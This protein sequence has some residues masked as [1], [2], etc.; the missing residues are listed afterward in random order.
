[1]A[2][3]GLAGSL[4]SL[5][6]GLPCVPMTS[7]LC[8]VPARLAQGGFR[9]TVRSVMALCAV[10]PGDA[11][12]A[13]APR[14]ARP[15]PDART[16]DTGT[17]TGTE[18]GSVWMSGKRCLARPGHLWTQICYMWPVDTDFRTYLMEY[19]LKG[20]CVTSLEVNSV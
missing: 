8:A 18:A 14:R 7:G 11:R 17:G 4:G 3:L 10:A 1:M 20:T 19:C 5:A 12:L 16:H 13:Q 15:G 2:R 6:L 9:P